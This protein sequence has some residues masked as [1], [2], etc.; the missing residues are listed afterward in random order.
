MVSSYNRVAPFEDERPHEFAVQS[1]A[2]VCS[3]S[4]VTGLRSALLDIVLDRSATSDRGG[5]AS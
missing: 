3:G 2:E 1:V 4:P 5:T